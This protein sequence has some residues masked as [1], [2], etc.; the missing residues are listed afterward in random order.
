MQGQHAA[1]VSTG[2]RELLLSSAA[3]AATAAASQ[4]LYPQ[5]A[6]ASV[7][8]NDDEPSA[9]LPSE[10]AVQDKAPAAAPAQPA[11]GSRYVVTPVSPGG[12]S[13]L[14]VVVSQLNSN[15][16]CSLVSGPSR[17]SLDACLAQ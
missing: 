9:A 1:A 14:A 12:T 4:L 11:A 3:A 13:G 2:R 5:P 8:D 10:A 7:I 15:C 16:S 6:R 17:P